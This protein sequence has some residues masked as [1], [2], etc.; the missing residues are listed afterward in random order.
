MIRVAINGF[1]RIGRASF[2]ALL[3][4]PGVEVVAINDLTDT[5]TLAHLLKYDSVY[6][7]FDKKVSATKEALVVAGKKYP[8]FAMKDPSALP[9]KDLKV[10]VVIE[11]TGIFLDEAGAGL[12]LK[13][14]A[15]KVVLSAP[16]KTDA[17]KT[18]VLGVNA[19]KLKKSDKIISMASCTTNCLAPVTDILTAK[20]GI[21]KAMMSTIHAYTADQTLV[22]GPHRDPRRARA[23]ALNIIPTTTGA[24]R[25][26]TLAIPSLKDKFDG[27][28]MRVPVPVGSLCDA[29]YVLNTK[30]TAEAV[31]AAIVAAS[32]LPKY[33]G[34]LVATDEP[35]VPSDIVGDT[36]SSIVDLSCT[37]VI[38]GDLAVSPTI[39][40]DTKGS[41]VAT[42]RPLYLGSLLA[43]TIAALTASAVVLVFST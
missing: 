29:T 1:G 6:G 20:F 42:S 17:I 13:A 2:K 14:G 36:A 30:T 34:L 43:A 28:S 27:M 10:D 12:H 4:R 24:A 31:N 3:A 25:A 15:K 26:V 19:D 7:R 21:K 23:A 16:G 40:L 11:S 9:W 5:T 39:S 37:R 41:S 22:D 35:I 32:K 18:F 33:K 38:D 8:V